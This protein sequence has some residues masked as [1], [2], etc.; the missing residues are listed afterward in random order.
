MTKLR[1]LVCLILCSLAATACSLEDPYGSICGREKGSIKYIRTP[2]VECTAE[3]VKNNS[4]VCG[5]FERSFES[6]NCPVG[7]TCEKDDDGSE[8]CVEPISNCGK[9]SYVWLGRCE[10]SNTENCGIHGGSCRKSIE[11]WLSGSCYE[12]VCILESCM[13]EYVLEN[14]KCVLRTN[15]DPE[16]PDPG[17]TDPETPDPGTT[18]PETPDPGTTDPEPSDIYQIDN[19]CNYETFSEV[20]DDKIGWYCDKQGKMK[21]LSCAYTADDAVCVAFDELKNESLSLIE[22]H[23][24][25]EICEFVGESTKQCVVDEDDPSVAEIIEKMCTKAGEQAYWRKISTEMTCEHGCSLN[26]EPS[27]YTPEP[28]DPTGSKLVVGDPC[29]PTTFVERCNDEGNIVYCN[30]ESELVDLK[31]CDSADSFCVIVKNI[32]ASGLNYGICTSEANK[33]DYNNASVTS[34]KT[35]GSVSYVQSKRCIATVDDALYWLDGSKI[36][37]KNACAPSLSDCDSEGRL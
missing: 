13:P 29:A 27:C 5:E 21:K 18:Y 20:C 2:N 11:G 34:C 23:T 4:K 36:Q 15:T 12:D 37:C 16:T 17:T 1:L 28:E 9:G 3:D 19:D 26:G 14:K 31:K 8:V 22:C 6:L 7:F 24:P 25:D 33:C 32:A 35:D 10:Q 30:S